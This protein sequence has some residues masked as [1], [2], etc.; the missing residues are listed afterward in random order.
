[1]TYTNPEISEA[2]G[3]GEITTSET[4]KSGSGTSIWQISAQVVQS[5]G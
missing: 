3:S 2:A 5:G 4:R 1:M